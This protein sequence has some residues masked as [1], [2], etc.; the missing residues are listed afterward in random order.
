MPVEKRKRQLLDV[1]EQCPAN[2]M[3]DPLPDR[4]HQKRLGK[5]DQPIAEI[6]HAQ[7]NQN[8]GDGFAVAYHRHCLSGDVRRKDGCAGAKSG[9]NEDHEKSPA[10]A[11]GQLPKPGKSPFHVLGLHHNHTAAAGTGYAAEIAGRDASNCHRLHPQS[12]THRLPGKS[13]SWPSVLHANHNP[14]LCRQPCTKSDQPAS[15]WKS[16]G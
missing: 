9:Q 10:I 8:P 12:G 2:V 15:Q 4:R 16:S 7:V 13:R 14:A 3:D 5:L 11:L 6:K 1:A